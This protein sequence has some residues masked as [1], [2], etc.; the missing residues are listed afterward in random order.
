[1][2]NKTYAKFQ[3]ESGVRLGFKNHMRR[4]FFKNFCPVCEDFNLGQFCFH[5]LKKKNNIFKSK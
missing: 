5:S 4:V 2:K 1:M 3:V